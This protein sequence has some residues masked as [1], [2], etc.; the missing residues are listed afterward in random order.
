MLSV[1]VGTARAA[2]NPAVRPRLAPRAIPQDVT[3]TELSP[4]QR[5]QAARAKTRSA[6]LR[7]TLGGAPFG[8]VLPLVG[9]SSAAATGTTVAEGPTS[10]PAGLIIPFS[11]SLCQTTNGDKAVLVLFV[12]HEEIEFIHGS[13]LN[14]QDQWTFWTLQTPNRALG[15]H[16]LSTACYDSGIPET[17]SEEIIYF[18]IN[19]ESE[20][21]W[22]AEGFEYQSTGP[23]LPGEL[24]ASAAGPGYVV[25]TPAGAPAG[26]D[27][28]PTVDAKPWTKVRIDFYSGA[29]EEWFGEETYLL[30]DPAVQRLSELPI[31]I[32]TSA[33]EGEYLVL[34]IACDRPHEKVGAFDPE[35]V[36]ANAEIELNE[37]AGG[38]LSRGELLGGG[39]NPAESCVLCFMAAH[40]SFGQP[41]DAPTGN[42]W[43]SFSDLAVPGRGFNLDLTRTYNSGN[44]A[45]DGPFGHGWSSSYGMNLEFPD[46]S[47]VVVS[48]E[49]G[50][51]VVFEAKSD[52]TYVAPPRVIATLTH[53][54]DGTW[55]FV[56]RTRETFVFNAA[57]QL[58]AESDRNGYTT[59]L[60][61]DAQGRLEAV[62]DPAGRRLSFAYSG[63]HIATATDP[64]GRAVGYTYD[65]DGN[66]TDVTDVAGGNTHFTYDAAHRLLTM[67]TPDQ[68]PGIP[69]STGA[70]LTNTYDAAG[71]VIEQVDQLGRRMTFKYEGEPLGPNGGYVLVTDPRGNETGQYYQWGELRSETRDPNSWESRSW[72]YEYDSATLAV[73][74]ITD[75]NGHSTL[76]TSDAAGNLLTEEDPLERVTTRSYDAHND[77]LTSTDPTGVTTT[78]TYDSAGNMLTRSRPLAGTAKTQTTKYVYGDPAHPSDLTEEVDPDGEAWKYT[79]DEAGDRVATTD[80]L[81]RRA[82]STYNID[83]WLLS[84][85]TPRGFTTT[86]Q[87]DPFGDTKETT[88]PLSNVTKSGF[89]PDRNLVS[90]TAADGHVTRYSYDATD[91][92]IAEHRPDGSTLE[93][94]YWP[95]GT[96]KEQIDGAGNA[97][98]YD[99]NPFGE[100]EKVTDPLGRAIYHSHDRDGNETQERQADGTYVTR[101][102][103]AANELTTIYYNDGK[104]PSV[105]GITYNGDGQRTAESDGTG[106]R[107]FTYDSLGR[108]T[109]TT[110]STGSVGYDY[111]LAGHLTKISYPN[112]KSVSREYDAA[113]ELTAVSDWLGH[114]TKYSYDKNAN[115]DSRETSGGFD[116]T[117]SYDVTD[118]L[119]SIA[120]AREGATLASFDYKRASNGQITSATEQ[121]GETTVASYAYDANRRL[122]AEGSRPYGYDAADN[123]TALG[124]GVTQAF[125]AANEM[126]SRTEPR[127]SGEPSEEEMPG[128][129]PAKEPEGESK[130][131]ETPSGGS[132]HVLPKST[133]TLGG[134]TSNIT[135]LARG[136]VG[137]ISYAFVPPVERALATTAARHKKTLDSAPI[138]TREPNDLFLALVSASGPARQA[139]TGIS[140]IG[141]RWSLLGRKPGAGGDVEIWQARAPQAVSG[142]ITAGLRVGGH[143][144]TMTVLALSSGSAVVGQA[145]AV[146]H[147][148]IPSL[149]L[150][151]AGEALLVSVGHS[152]GQK[153]PVRPSTSEHLLSSFL[154][155]TSGT[156]GWIQIANRIAS[157]PA[158]TQASRAPKWSLLG[159]AIT[160]R[161][162]VTARSPTTVPSL[163][164]P[165]REGTTGTSPRRSTSTGAVASARTADAPEVEAVTR[166]YGYDARGD[167]TVDKTGGVTRTLDYN[168]AN[169][170]IGLQGV[171]TY[172]YNSDGLRTSKTVQGAT[173]S[174]VWNEAEPVPSLLASGS[175]YYIY[176]PEE[177]P[178]EQITGATVYFLHQDQQGSTR[179]LATPAGT[180]LG[181]YDYDAWGNVTRQSGEATT[182]LQYAGQYTDA[183]TG[184]QYLRARYYDPRTAQ[185]L[186]VDPE[187]AATLAPYSYAAEDPVAYGDPEGTNPLTDALGA[188]LGAAGDSAWHALAK[189]PAVVKVVGKGAGALNPINDFETGEAIANSVEQCGGYL[190]D[191]IYGLSTHKHACGAAAGDLGNKAIGEIP[192]VGAAA[193]LDLKELTTP[194]TAGSNTPCRVHKIV[195]GMDVYGLYP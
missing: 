54:E 93:T 107:T 50:A 110:A 123:P 21:L 18:G 126:T 112:G 14:Y 80:P 155:R 28:C 184:Y 78:M 3:V 121:N 26:S 60:A 17:S 52:G 118:Q 133:G 146:G 140:G 96:V 181:R 186:T 132:E 142:V 104:T 176:G 25:S 129:E 64:T 183:E 114:T 85:T 68:A 124:P 8:A 81:D 165:G 137:G 169:E 32:P 136:G 70:V 182:E 58:T 173:T 162:A 194:A 41:V 139:V 59:S 128:E 195:N 147:K 159:V 39:R 63:N 67:R 134:G 192:V 122:T 76:M 191:T 37:P 33:K 119:S 148:S 90:S 116:E 117:R 101:D 188:V 11:T 125:D 193:A 61:Y 135:G 153:R 13:G 77:L 79:Y 42:F 109:A 27:V 49:N 160:S 43:H 143:P 69:S 185:F 73:T 22:K 178:I 31:Q 158:A 45:A 94:T 166:K 141:L 168:G 19:W 1:T 157:P 55:S 111:D 30:A 106:A 151:S 190:N 47:H 145:A 152:E 130:G 53:A 24:S 144:A 108:L 88:D 167:R 179:L 2:A 16:R 9:R 127:V 92:R 102:Y 6:A 150:G 87:H 131:G 56:R 66:L 83:G 156:A 115:V 65:S 149:L 138:R 10:A 29:K 154:D 20:A 75:P 51:Q 72:S 98:R 103:D 86:Y 113:G 105:T 177:E 4:R 40:M 57:G 187:H 36:F 172:A 89:D 180:V 164:T 15:S 171:A 7:E 170:L 5:R 95:D 91:E 100:V 163:G 44:A 12:D 161:V 35:Y 120:D 23:Q 74:R 34:A 97:T 71:R 84:S 62:T 46:S 189:T 48:Q 99:Y 175:T 38:P 174:F 82:T